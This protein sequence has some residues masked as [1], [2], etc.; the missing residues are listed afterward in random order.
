M[1]RDEV[2]YC[3][4]YQFYRTLVLFFV[5]WKGSSWAA[6]HF[7][8]GLMTDRSLWFN[9]MYSIVHYTELFLYVWVWFVIVFGSEWIMKIPVE[10]RGWS[11]LVLKRFVLVQ[12]RL[13]RDQRASLSCGVTGG[14]GPRH[15]Q[16]HRRIFILKA[17]ICMTLVSTTTLINWGSLDECSWKSW[18]V[19]NLT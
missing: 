6:Q 5:Y 9:N 18:R 2:F 7:K 8:R 12:W 13:E 4:K 19:L 17:Q 1:W 15:N 16:K 11:P 10:C 14:T 3:L